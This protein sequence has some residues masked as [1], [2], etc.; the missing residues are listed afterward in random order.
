MRRLTIG[1]LL[2][3][4]IGGLALAGETVKIGFF[5]P[6]TGFAAADGHAALIGA[7]IAVDFI[8][9]AGG[10]GGKPVEKLCA[11]KDYEQFF[12]GQVRI[13]LSNCG[14]IDAEDIDEYTARGG[15][16]ALKK[17]IS[18]TPEEVIDEVKKSGL[19]GRGGGGFPTG[20]K[21]KFCRD[22]ESDMKYVVCNADE[23]EPGT[24]KDREILTQVPFKVLT[25]MAVCAKVTG[26][27][28]G[29]IYLPYVLKNHTKES[30]ERHNKFMREYEDKHKLCPKCGGEEHITTLI[31]YVL[32]VG[33]EEEY[34]DK[35]ICICSICGNRHITHDRISEADWKAK[36]DLI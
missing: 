24:F 3:A 19:R 29:Y 32:E 18:M 20:M 16:E 34:K 27:K 10:I 6:L 4:F 22:A 30:L 14:E 7:Q 15:Y 25:G 13:V 11:G 5:S 31:G 36:M 33:K 26:A 1:L 23:G 8:N 21:W 9:A 35:N 17:V 12:S 2:F 28:E